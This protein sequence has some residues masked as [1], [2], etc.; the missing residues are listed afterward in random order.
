MGVFISAASS[1]I[2]TLEK[3]SGNSEI[4]SFVY[5]ITGS[6]ISGKTKRHHALNVVFTFLAFQSSL[7]VYLNTLEGPLL[8]WKHPILGFEFHDELL[9]WILISGVLQEFFWLG[10]IVSPGPSPF[11]IF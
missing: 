4:L 9:C 6:R 11:L 3:L 5:S 2:Q 10:I 8:L 1:A 7:G